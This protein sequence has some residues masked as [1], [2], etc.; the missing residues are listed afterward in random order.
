MGVDAM[1]QYVEKHRIRVKV[2]ATGLALVEGFLSLASQSGAHDGPETILELLNSDQ[3]VVPLIR[4]TDESVV[5]LMR[6]NIESVAA[7]ADVEPH[8]VCPPSYLVTREEHVE[9]MFADGGGIEGLL[10][11]ELPEHLNRASDFLNGAGSFFPLV[12]RTGTI[13][14]NKAKLSGTRVFTASPRP[15]IDEFRRSA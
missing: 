13:L 8:W 4:A 2:A 3:R 7:G 9:V 6:D 10:Q 15:L 12:T 11:M 1:P 5:L 14:V